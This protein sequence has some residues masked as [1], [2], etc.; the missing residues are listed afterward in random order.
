MTGALFASPV[1]AAK[2]TST[3]EQRA[4]VVEL[5]KQYEADVLGPKSKDLATV[6]VKWWTDVPDLTVNWCANLLVDERPSEEYAGAMTVQSLVA[7][8]VYVIEHADQGPTNRDVWLAGM[9]GVV[10]AY[11]NVLARDPAKKDDF[12]EK[13]SELQR[14]GKLG[15]YVDAHSSTCK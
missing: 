12:L 8:G 9:Q 1:A 7:A 14:T 6:L 3:P 4:K 10:R 11:Q 15:E 2:K 13:L 5:S